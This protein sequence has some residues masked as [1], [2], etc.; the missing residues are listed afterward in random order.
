MMQKICHKC[1]TEILL[2]KWCS[3]ECLKEKAEREGVSIDDLLLEMMR[4]TEA[5][6]QNAGSESE[7]G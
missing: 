1:G 5:L 3:Y 4:V 2:N 6:Q 7:S